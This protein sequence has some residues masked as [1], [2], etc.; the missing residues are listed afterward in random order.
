MSSL[1]DCAFDVM[2]FNI[3]D[4]LSFDKFNYFTHYYLAFPPNASTKVESVGD[5]DAERS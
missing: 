4:S 1:K 2:V 5:K 3:S